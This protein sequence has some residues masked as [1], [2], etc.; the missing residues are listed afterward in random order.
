MKGKYWEAVSITVQPKMQFK[1]FFPVMSGIMRWPD[2][3]QLRFIDSR[4]TGLELLTREMVAAGRENVQTLSVTPGLLAKDQIYGMK[5][6]STRRY[7]QVQWRQRDSTPM[8]TVV[9]K[10]NWV[11]EE[12]EKAKV[13]LQSRRRYQ[14]GKLVRDKCRRGW[15][16]THLPELV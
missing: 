7:G 1:Y 14:L 2:C 11:T 6:G 9:I 15:R 13:E 4:P 8:A 16:D 10:R 5:S 3:R 12:T